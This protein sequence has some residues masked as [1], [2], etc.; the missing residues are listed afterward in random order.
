MAQHTLSVE[1]QV[2]DILRALPARIS[3][4]LLPWAE[5]SP[6]RPALLEASRTWTCGHLASA[7]AATRLLL[8]NSGV[9]AGDRVML[10]GENS[11]VFVAMLFAAAGLDAWPVLV[12]PRLSTREVDAIRDHCVARRVIY[13]P[14]ASPQAREHAAHHGAAGAEVAGLGPVLLGPL[15]EAA[16]PEPLDPNISNRIAA[17]IYTSGTTGRPKGVMLTHRGLLFVAAISARLR[18]LGPDDRLYGVLPMFH[19]VGL[20]VVLLGALLSGAAVYLAPRFDPVAA[21][22]ALESARITVMLGA[23]AMFA[24]MVEYAKSKGIPSLKFPALRIISSSSAPLHAPLK[25]GVEKLFGLVLHNGYGA[26]ECS[27]NIAQ[28]RVESP[29]AD[30]SVGRVFPGTEISLVGT[31]GNPVP[32]GEV[33]EL[34]VRGPSVMKGYYRAPK[35]TAEAVD[36]SGWFHTRDLAR[37]DQGNLFI[38]GRAKELIVRFG[39]NVYPAEVEAVLNAHPGVVR[40]AVIGRTI[41]GQGNEEVLAFI[42]LAPGASVTTNEL[43]AYAAK[44]LAP[45]KQPSQFIVVPVMPMTATGKIVKA[46][47]AKMAADAT[48]RS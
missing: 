38:V 36:A 45:Y 30:I 4:V 40:S 39:F 31:D 46:E 13:I 44:Q 37:L 35:E 14:S 19:A 6:D 10:I 7:V 25:S 24:L 5:R 32:E 18:S 42:Q 21:L 33:G 16:N 41:E 34:R 15:N 29:R 1:D 48:R 28:T 26:T 23:P 12:N 22:A 2:S 17:L 20:S 47:L 11:P 9:R 43:A 27:P 3:D 8:R